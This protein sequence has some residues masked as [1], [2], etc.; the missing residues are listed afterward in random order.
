[1]NRTLIAMLSVVVVVA[2]N[3]F[4]A[5]GDAEAKK[6]WDTSIAVGLNLTQ[7][8]SDT[9]LGSASIRTEHEEGAHSFRMGA[10]GAYGETEVTREGGETDDEVTAQNAKAAANYK[11][12]A[13]VPYLYV[14]ATWEHDDVADVDYRF[15]GGPGVGTSIINRD[16]LKFETDV[17]VAY[18]R[19]DVGGVTD[20]YASVRFSEYVKWQISETAKLWQEAVILPRADDFDD[21]LLNGELGVEA[22]L[23][24]SMS[25]RIVVQ[26]KYDSTPA[27]GQEK[28]DVAVISALAWRL[29]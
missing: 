6:D 22:A 4:S 23:N 9:V 12:K 14:D 19:E 26:D 5:E 18:V 15:I 21:Y 7:G 1:M 20:D 27:A 3:A 2:G 24:A 11:L 29:P 25:L 17:G 28:N 8:N 13:D 10:E 16:D